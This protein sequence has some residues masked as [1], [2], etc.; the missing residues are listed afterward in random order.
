[1]TKNFGESW[2]KKK[3]SKIQLQTYHSTDGDTILVGKNNKQKRDPNVIQRLEA[4]RKQYEN[5]DKK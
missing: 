2:E 3:Q 4:T 1:M 5:K